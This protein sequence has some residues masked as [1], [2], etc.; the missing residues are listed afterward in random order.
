MVEKKD[1][2]KRT[3][4][5]E[6]KTAGQMKSIDGMKRIWEFLLWPSQRI[7]LC[8]LFKGMLQ[9]LF[10]KIDENKKRSY[11]MYR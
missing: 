3:E 7:T 4:M 11:A 1:G 5:K 10:Y 2:D 8:A 9:D 6:K